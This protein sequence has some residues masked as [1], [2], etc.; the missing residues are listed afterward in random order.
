[1]RRERVLPVVVA[2][3]LLVVAPCA[4][5]RAQ[6]TSTV[7]RVLFAMDQGVDDDRALALRAELGLRG[8]AL[9]LI[10][11]LAGED[12]AARE[13]QARLLAQQRGAYATLWLEERR[14]EARAVTPAGPVRR[15]TMPR[16][17]SSIDP[18]VLAVLL[19][20]L[21]DEAM[22]MPAP[23]PPEST[24]VVV[25]QQADPAP[26]PER[27]APEPTPEPAPFEPAP[28]EPAPPEPAPPEPAAPPLGAF[29]SDVVVV[30]PATDL[31]GDEP[32][33]DPAH[34]TRDGALHPYAI[35]DAVG[36]FVW[37]MGNFENHLHL[38]QRLG[39]GLVADRF[40]GEITGDL[41]IEH[42]ID[43]SYESG[44]LLQAQ[45]FVGASLPADIIS[46]DFGGVVGV[47]FH[48]L[49]ADAD[50]RASNFAVRLGTAVGLTAP[51]SR[52][53]FP[54]RARIELGVFAVPSPA[55]YRPFTNVVLGIGFW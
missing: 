7:G 3:V 16:S 10:P 9:E 44:V 1:M 22:A 6:D 51:D 52:A 47:A 33:G 14:N 15:A 43:G 32:A 23:E 28:F 29:V 55:L 8:L 35:V 38:V 2:L 30:P 27:A 34:A 48:N 39:A 50:P 18:R 5:A 42:S 49:L 21:L 53:V 13:R 41:G 19:A 46:F 26:T 24:V 40:R 11:A 31:E 25:P 20:S 4:G 54:F 17:A 12:D 37:R 36:G 45:A